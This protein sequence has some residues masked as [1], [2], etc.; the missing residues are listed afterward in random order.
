VERNQ[1][2][3]MVARIGVSRLSSCNSVCHNWIPYPVLDISRGA[4]T[5]QHWVWSSSPPC[6][7][8]CLVGARLQAQIL[9]LWSTERSDS[10][11]RYE[12]WPVEEIIRDRASRAI[13]AARGL[14]TGDR[15]ALLFSVR[16]SL[17]RIADSFEATEH[18]HCDEVKRI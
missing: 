11:N 14:M 7:P 16:I 3:G 13:P 9:T 15:D 10:T 4:E 5:Q 17:K 2:L 12:T 18:C 8:T 6:P 1:S